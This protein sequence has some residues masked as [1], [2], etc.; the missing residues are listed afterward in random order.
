MS[1]RS[2]KSWNDVTIIRKFI[3]IYHFKTKKITTVKEVRITG[4]RPRLHG[5]TNFCTD[6][7]LQVSTLRLHGTGGTERIFEKLS[8]QF[9]DLEKAAKCASF[10]PCKYLFYFDD[11]IFRLLASLCFDSEDTKHSR[12]CFNGYPNTLNFV[13]NTPLRVAFSTLFSVFGYPD[14]TLSLV[15]WYITSNGNTTLSIPGFWQVDIGK[16]CAVFEGKCKPV[17]G[18][19]GQQNNPSPPQP[20]RNFV[21]LLPFLFLSF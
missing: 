7:N 20:N 3:S 9:W 21:V 14:A 16:F 2:F 8:V 5:P 4:L 6:K 11:F 13:K 17:L 15:L 1:L 19:H 10:G 12:Q 18:Q